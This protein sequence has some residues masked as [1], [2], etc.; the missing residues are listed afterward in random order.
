MKHM[1][2]AAKATTTTDQGEVTLLVSTY[3]RDRGGDVI[4]PG[5]F[6]ETI[7]KWQRSK[8][9]IPLHFDHKGEPESIIGAADPHSMRETDQGLIVEAKLDLEE[10][11]KAREV[12]RLVRSGVVACSFGYLA[13]ASRE[14]SDGTRLLTKIDLFEVTLTPSPMNPETRVIDYKAASAPAVSSDLAYILEM[15]DDALIARYEERERAEA[16][17]KR[18]EAET[19]RAE[20]PI[21]VASFPVE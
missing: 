16:A 17:S 3:D 4:E 13:E 18:L 5:A 2:L 8:K 12:W 21:T 10:S 14:Q 20:T 19:K 15:D 6:A 11:E 1:T 9:K 7:A